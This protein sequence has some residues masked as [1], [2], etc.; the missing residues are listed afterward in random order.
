MCNQSLHMSF[1]FSAL[2]ICGQ[3]SVR[4]IVIAG[5]I[6]M[7]PY[8]SCVT[9]TTL[10]PRSQPSLAQLLHTC[11][12]ISLRLY[13]NISMTVTV[14][15]FSQ[16]VQVTSALNLLI[17]LAVIKACVLVWRCLTKMFNVM[18]TQPKCK[19][20]FVIF[21]ILFTQHKCKKKFIH[22]VLWKFD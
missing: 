2:E 20:K 6:Y 19:K 12:Y 14:Y 9:D 7:I 3:E 4:Y 1:H 18:F 11:R 21:K 13:T 15:H 16:S 8:M 10:K 5:S 17:K 22:A